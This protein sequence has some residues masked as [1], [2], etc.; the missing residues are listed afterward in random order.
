MNRLYYGDCLAVMQEIPDNSID[1]IYLD[2]PFYPYRRYNEVY[3]KKTGRLLPADELA[4]CDAWELTED[5]ER[6]LRTMPVLMR[7]SGIE[8]ST[9]EFWRLWMEALRWTQ[10]SLLAY[11]TY[12]VERLL[13]MRSL[14]KPTASLYLHCEQTSSHYS[15]VLLDA[16]FGHDNFQNEIVWH[17][18]NLGTA[19]K[20][21]HRNHDTILFYSKSPTYQFQKIS[22]IDMQDTWHDIPVLRGYSKEREAIKTQKPLALLERIIKV[23]SRIGETVLDP[24]CGSGTTLEAAQRLGRN[25]VGIDIAL[26]I[27]GG[28]AQER[29]VN[30]CGLTEGKD[31]TFEGVPRTVEE[32]QLF[33]QRD[34]FQFQRWAIEQVDGF[35]IAKRLPEGDAEGRIY[36]DMPEERGMQSMLVQVKGGKHI[37]IR[38]LRALQD[39]LEKGHAQMA[40]L[41]VMEPLGDRQQ[42]NFAKNMAEAGNLE[43]GGLSY[44]RIQ[45]L[46]VDEILDGKQF[47]LPDTPKQ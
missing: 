28:I 22:D 3:M 23:S 35:C 30:R 12:M 41:I 40:G 33:W 10:P 18:R 1:L 14:M 17:F 39:V 43:T 4:F 21:F 9:V 25:W 31:F 36:F 16:I 29:L 15:K 34:K 27:A 26:H 24:F 13:V 32:A 44:P 8:E 42:S 5:R 38:A 2:P 46:S 19:T 7:E 47:L 37:N 45:M 11:M 6:A 20:R